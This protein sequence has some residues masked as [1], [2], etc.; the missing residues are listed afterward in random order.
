MIPLRISCADQAA[1]QEA[2]QAVQPATTAIVVGVVGLV[3]LWQIYTLEQP[4]EL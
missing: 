1:C 3:F 4:G 2:M